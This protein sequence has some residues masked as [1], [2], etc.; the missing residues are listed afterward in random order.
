MLKKNQ[1]LN[2]KLTD[3]LI[4]KA[5]NINGIILGL[6][7]YCNY[8]LKF[9]IKSWIENETDVWEDDKEIIL[10]DSCK[11]NRSLLEITNK[12]RTHW[13]SYSNFL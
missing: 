5:Q 10:L 12:R 11:G 6:T 13:R 4:F 2:T 8:I 7:I 1:F 9:K 3:L